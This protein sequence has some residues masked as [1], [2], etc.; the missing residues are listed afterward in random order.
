MEIEIAKDPA[1]LETEYNVALTR[2]ESQSI[3]K[4]ALKKVIEAANGEVVI[5]PFEMHFSHVIVSATIERDCDVKVLHCKT[6]HLRYMLD[7]LQ[8]A[9]EDNASEK[10]AKVTDSTGETS[11]AIIEPDQRLD[12]AT[13]HLS[14]YLIDL[15]MQS[16]VVPDSLAGEYY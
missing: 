4:Q 13:E 10:Q 15:E 16:F 2:F 9:R 6:R 12:A 11:A 8:A 1:G 7:Y 5:D 14:G 3:S